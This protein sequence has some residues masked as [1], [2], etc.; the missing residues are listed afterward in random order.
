MQYFQ[1]YRNTV[2][3]SLLSPVAGK[4]WEAGKDFTS[5]NIRK[6][7]GEDIPSSSVLLVEGAIW[8]CESSA[9]GSGEQDPKEWAR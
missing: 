1:S 7:A 8:H 6:S 5:V 2:P 3:V 4:D 9:S